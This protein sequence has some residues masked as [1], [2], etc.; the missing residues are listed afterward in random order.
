MRNILSYIFNSNVA[1]ALGI[2]TLV[3]G[4][5]RLLENPTSTGSTRTGSMAIA[6]FVIIFG[7]LAYKSAKSRLSSP[8]KSSVIRVVFEFCCLILAFALIVLQNNLKYLIATDPVPNLI[9][10]VWVVVA[11]LVLIVRNRVAKR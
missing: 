5:I 9:V 11:Y 7:A 6:G 4:L 8:Q 2:L 1:L 10:P 3:V